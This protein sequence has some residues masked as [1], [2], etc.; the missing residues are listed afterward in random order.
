MWATPVNKISFSNKNIK[1]ALSLRNKT[2]CSRES[3]PE[4]A[5]GP[6]PQ[7]PL[8][9]C[10][11]RVFSSGRERRRQLPRGKHGGITL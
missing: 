9:G 1:H 10:G 7:Q 5:A 6:G 11:S 8:Q 2:I 3:A 4:L